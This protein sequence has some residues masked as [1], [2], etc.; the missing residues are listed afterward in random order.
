MGLTHFP[1]GI[2]VRTASASSGAA[3]GAG[4]FDCQDMF[5]AGTASAAVV[6][7]GTGNFSD[8]IGSQQVYTYNF[9]GASTAAEEVY[10]P[11]VVAGSVE[12]KYQVSSGTVGTGADIEV[13]VNDTAGANILSA[14]L[15]SA[16]T[17]GSAIGSFSSTTASVAV[18]SAQGICIVKASCATAYGVGLSVVIQKTA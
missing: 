16:G 6:V 3:A 13:Y 11:V 14:T 18:T 1:N 15:A 2:T 9:A 8:I 17:A 4:D 7:A 10:F 12:I 5:I